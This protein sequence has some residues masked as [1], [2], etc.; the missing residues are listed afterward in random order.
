MNVI[1]ILD[2]HLVLYLVKGSFFVLLKHHAFILNNNE[3]L[4]IA[5][6]LYYKTRYCFP[7]I[8]LTQ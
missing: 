4:E 6:L 3:D 1:V 2:K 8:I 7:T 5:T